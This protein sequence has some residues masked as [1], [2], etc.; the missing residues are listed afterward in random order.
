M[1]FKGFRF[2]PFFSPKPVGH[3][4]G[5]RRPPS[6]VRLA[7]NPFR[8]GRCKPLAFE[9]SLSA[10]GV[11]PPSLLVSDGSG[12]GVVVP[13]LSPVMKDTH[14]KVVGDGVGAGDGSAGVASL[15]VPN[16]LVS[17]LGVFALSFDVGLEL[18]VVG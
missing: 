13:V 6:K 12:T 1:A 16:L 8:L 17:S 3:L 2:G 5:F 15:L 11:E 4:Q 18:L 7:L 14:A 10:A 9:A